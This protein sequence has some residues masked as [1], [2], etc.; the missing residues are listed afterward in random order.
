MSIS[1][2]EES[3]EDIMTFEAALMHLSGDVITAMSL[4]DIISEKDV[5]HEALE[6]ELLDFYCR[7]Y[8]DCADLIQKYSKNEQNEDGNSL[9]TLEDQSTLLENLKN[10]AGQYLN[11]LKKTD[12]VEERTGNILEYLLNADKYLLLPT[13][14]TELVSDIIHP[15]ESSSESEIIGESAEQNLDIE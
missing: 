11:T 7:I 8:P 5:S 14:L 1:K 6:A 9:F 15:D 12:L 2:M 3:I 4:Y 10:N 13:E